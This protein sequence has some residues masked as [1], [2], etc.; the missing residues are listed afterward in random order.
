MF[1]DVIGG[2]GIGPVKDIRVA[3]RDAIGMGVLRRG[4]VITQRHTEPES[5][6]ELEV[7]GPTTAVLLGEFRRVGGKPHR[8]A[9]VITRAGNVGV[10]QQRRLVVANVLALVADGIRD[11][12]TEWGT[13]L[14]A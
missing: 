6:V 11:L 10:K 12:G 5:R 4:L 2:L 3:I 7:K 13:L 1:A 9:G 8:V 14:T